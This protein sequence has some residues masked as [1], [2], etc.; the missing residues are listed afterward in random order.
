MARNEALDRIFQPEKKPK[1]VLPFGL[2]IRTALIGAAVVVIFFSTTLLALNLLSPG[3]PLDESKPAMAALTELQPVTRTSV[4]IAPVA[5]ANAAIRDAIESNAP[6]GLTGKN[7]NPLA[8]LLGKADIGWN[9]SRGPFAITGASSSLNISTTLNGSLR[10]TGQVA[11]QTG[12]VTGA[13]DRPAR[14][15]A[16][17]TTCRSSPRACSTSAPTFAATS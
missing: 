13:L 14:Q 2:T 16:R 17:R 5:V 11:N 8:D 6:R 7:E 12:N 9:V 1:A 10:V 3:N 15:Q 4:I